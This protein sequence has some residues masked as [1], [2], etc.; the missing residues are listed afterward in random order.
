MCV[1]VYINLCNDA[2]SQV[3]AETCHN[4]TTLPKRI[5]PWDMDV[6][7]LLYPKEDRNNI[8][9]NSFILFHFSS[10]EIRYK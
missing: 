9:T 7:H 5:F 8:T 3:L 10:Y 6:L 4:C 1:C 2:N